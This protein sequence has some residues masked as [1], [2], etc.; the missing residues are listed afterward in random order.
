MSIHINAKKGD[1]AKV[2]LMPGDPLRAAWIAKTFLAKVKQVN[3]V[4]GIYGFTGYTK[5]H[6]RI[7]VMASGMGQP[8]IGIYSHELYA[9]YG[10]DA[11]IRIGTCGVFNKAINSRDII[12]AQTASSDFNWFTDFHL[13]GTYSAGADFDLLEAAVSESRKAKLKFFVGN[14]LSEATFYHQDKDWWKNWDKIGT[15]A[16]EMESYALYATAALLHKKALTILTVTDHFQ[17]K[18][19]LSSKERQTGLTTMAKLAIKVAERFA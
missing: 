5:N 19:V 8:S 17:K 7:S 1:F 15:L 3:D 4:R 14:V 10:V 18:E 6:K 12:L 2:V 9:E 13:S 11:I 16:C